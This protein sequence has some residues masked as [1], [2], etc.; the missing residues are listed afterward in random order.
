LTVFAKWSSVRLAI[1][2]LLNRHRPSPLHQLTEQL[3]AG[4]RQLQPRPGTRQRQRA[5]RRTASV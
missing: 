2:P 5:E 4:L 1:F 3:E